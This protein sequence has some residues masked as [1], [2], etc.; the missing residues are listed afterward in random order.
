VNKLSGAFDRRHAISVERLSCVQPSC[1]L[2]SGQM[3]RNEAN[4]VDR[5]PSMRHSHDLVPVQLVFHCPPSPMALDAL[6]RVNE[7]S[8][9]IKQHRIAFEVCHERCVTITSAERSASAAPFA[10]SA[11][12]RC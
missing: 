9:Q 1:F 12:C 2:F 4:S 6:G 7:D 5:W 10:A 8:V 11:A 3:W